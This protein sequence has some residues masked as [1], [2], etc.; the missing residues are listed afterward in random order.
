MRLCVFVVM[1][2]KF[3][4]VFGVLC[5]YWFICHEI[6]LTLVIMCQLESGFGELDRIL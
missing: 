3:M 2:L 5:V 1:L 6:E 4:F